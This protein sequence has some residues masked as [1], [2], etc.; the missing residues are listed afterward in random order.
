[1]SPLRDVSARGTVVVVVAV[2]VGVGVTGIVVGVAPEVG[3]VVV[4]VVVDTG[5]PSPVLDVG[6]F[7]E[8]P[9]EPDATFGSDVDVVDAVDDVLVGLEEPPSRTV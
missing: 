1:M 9:E 2:V 3:V 7:E 4:V 8:I 5:P 6:S